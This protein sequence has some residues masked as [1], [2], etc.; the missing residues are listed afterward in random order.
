MA[1]ANPH[2]TGVAAYPALLHYCSCPKA[3]LAF[4]ITAPAHSRETLV[5]VYPGLFLDASSHLYKRVCPSVGRSVRPSVRYASAKTAFLSCFWPRWEPVLKQMINKHVFR[6]S[7]TTKLF[8][9]SICL[10]VYP[11]MSHDQLTQRHGPDASLPGRAC[12]FFFY[13]FFFF[14]SFLFFPFPY[15]RLIRTPAAFPVVEQLCI[16]LPFPSLRFV[17]DWHRG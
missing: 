5:N 3:S 11:N 12:F 4:S 1:P 6:A 8:Y 17:N 15:G 13:L 9:P 10:S 16:F 7:F 14:F 2:A